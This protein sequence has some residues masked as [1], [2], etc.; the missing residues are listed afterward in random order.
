MRLTP[1]FLWL[2]GNRSCIDLSLR[3][4]YQPQARG[5]DAIAQTPVMSLISD[6]RT[7]GRDS[8]AKGLYRMSD[9][10]YGKRRRVAIPPAQYKEYKANG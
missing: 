6:S 8:M 4:G 3:T 10:E 5:D 2:G 1:T 7:C 9:D